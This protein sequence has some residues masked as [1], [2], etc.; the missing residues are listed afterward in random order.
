M[1]RSGPLASASNALQ[2]EFAPAMSVSMAGPSFDSPSAVAVDL[3]GNVYVA[4]T[5]NHT[6]RKVVPSTEAVTTLAGLAGTSGSSDGLGSA[7]RFFGPAGIAVDSTGN[8]YVADTNNHTVRVGV[9]SVIPTI[10][11][12]PQGQTVSAGNSVQFSVT[13]TG[14]PSPTYQ[15]YFNG[16]SI[17]GA[18]NS[19][20][21]LSN[22]QSGNSGDYTVVVSNVVGSVTSD[23][24]TLTVNAAAQ[25][26]VGGSS[27]GGAGSSGGGGA[28]SLWFFSAMLL[29]VAVRFFRGRTR[30]NPS[31]T[32]DG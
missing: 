7:V 11:T 21:S 8:L 23:G 2:W 25:P 1:S 17:N 29:L 6:I 18:T 22:A 15:W 19:A 26:S 12:Q 9:L 13:A 5:D 32:V 31:S 14:R 27:S 4:D 20:Y 16:T 30:T 10:Q 28:F 24:A 3:S